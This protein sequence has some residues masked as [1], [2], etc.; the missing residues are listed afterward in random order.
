MLKNIAER[1][2]V[3]VEKSWITIDNKYLHVTVSIGATMAK[4]GDTIESLIHRADSQMYI[5]KHS[6]RNWVSLDTTTPS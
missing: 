6:G 5:S 1:I 2:R 4:A 3:F